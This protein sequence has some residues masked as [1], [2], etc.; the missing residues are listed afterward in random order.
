VLRHA[1]YSLDY[2]GEF[3]AQRQNANTLVATPSERFM[4]EVDMRSRIRLWLGNLALAV[5]AT[6]VALLAAEF[7]LRVTSSRMVFPEMYVEDRHTVYR[8]KPD[9]NVRTVH[10]GYFAYT[11]RV[12]SQGFRGANTVGPKSAARRRLLFVGDSFTFG[13]GVD[14][15]ATYPAKVEARLR[16]WCA[17]PVETVN[18]GVGGFGTSHELSFLQHY[19]WQ[20][21]PDIVVLGFLT[22]DQYD[23]S[24]SGL[25][26]LVDG[27]LEEIPASERPG[28]GLIRANE[29]I[30]AY[31]WLVQHSTLFNWTRLKIGTLVAQRAEAKEAERT[32]VSIA[33]D[34]EK[35][36]LERWHL[37][38][39][40]LEQIRAQADSHG[41]R[42]IVAII[43]HRATLTEYY[44]TGRDPDVN[45]MLEI[46]SQL[47]LA[48]V[49][50]A[51]YLSK[52]H[53][54][55]P[56]LSFYL[57]EG[58]FNPT[59]YDLVAAAVARPLA[60]LLNCPLPVS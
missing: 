20:L 4:P 3:D 56:P 2:V 38:A 55:A 42:L 52:A 34:S 27:R 18:G 33:G 8:L 37:T 13:V 39:A 57:N 50:V 6:I 24:L 36:D 11:Y 30:P 59:G 15:S 7:A 28:R 23:N 40:I 25:H 60:E 22:S 26:R 17:T 12:N 31:A 32:P 41:S 53:P 49:D 10:A 19:G 46:C 1:G 9:V 58:H 45:Q 14:D 44:A 29:H 21:E 47:Q 48:C 5:A 51:E 35:R 54:E 16:Q 43:P